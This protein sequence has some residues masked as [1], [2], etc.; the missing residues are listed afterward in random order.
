MKAIP[1]HDWLADNV[2]NYRSLSP[3]ALEKK[4]REL[5]AAKKFHS[6]RVATRAYTAKAS[7][8]VW[9]GKE[10]YSHVIEA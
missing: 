6:L 4:M 7:T 3:E 8:F 5:W 9:V 2:P 1:I 10:V